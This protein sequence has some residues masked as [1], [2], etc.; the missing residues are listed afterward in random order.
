MSLA[1]FIN[2]CC[3]RLTKHRVAHT[4]LEQAGPYIQTANCR[5]EGSNRPRAERLRKQ[6]SLPVCCEQTVPPAA[7]QSSMFVSL[8]RRE[9]LFG[10]L[11][12]LWLAYSFQADA[13]A[14]VLKSMKS[15]KPGALTLH[16]DLE[17]AARVYWLN[18]D[19]ACPI[20]PPS[21]VLLIENDGLWGLQGP[22]MNFV[23]F[24]FSNCT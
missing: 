5:L 20:A 2:S 9:A 16:N 15:E 8:K 13:A 22:T 12:G 19:G 21:D 17:A 3:D 10:S 23:F 7:V 6:S 1:H 14:A 24:I 18:Y 4:G 11:T